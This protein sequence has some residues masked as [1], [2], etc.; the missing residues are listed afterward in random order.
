MEVV[1]KEITLKLVTDNGEYINEQKINIKDGDTLV[2]KVPTDEYGIPLYSTEQC[3]KFNNLIATS[4]KG[5]NTNPIFI[6]DNF[7]FEII[8]I[9]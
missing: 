5:M 4:L 7:K 2:I 1:L 9:K 6:P 3:I 8:S